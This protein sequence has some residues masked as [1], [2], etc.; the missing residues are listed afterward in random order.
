MPNMLTPEQIKAA[1]KMLGITQRELA[2]RIGVKLNT[3]GGWECGAG[4][5]SGPAAILIRKL[6]E[7]AKKQ[8]A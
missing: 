1:R 5:C 8:P 4:K 6:V 3:V 2:E 7:E